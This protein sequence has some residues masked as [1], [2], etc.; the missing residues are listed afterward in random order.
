MSRLSGLLR[1]AKQ[2]EPLLDEDLEPEI[3]PLQKRLPSSPYFERRTPGRQS[4]T[5]GMRE[6]KEGKHNLMN[7][8]A[9]G[10]DET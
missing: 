1:A 9:T 10:A 2:L 8:R 6:P 4:Q 5:T 7:S 3:W